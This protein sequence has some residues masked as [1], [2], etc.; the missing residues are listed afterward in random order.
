MPFRLPPL[1]SLRFFEAAGRHQSFKRAA[2]EVG[3]TPSAISHGIVALE[4]WIG[5]ELFVREARGLRLTP[6]G[7]E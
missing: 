6:A 2:E 3:V 1:A 5:V 4:R 7:T